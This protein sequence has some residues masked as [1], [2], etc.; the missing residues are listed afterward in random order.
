MK[1]AAYLLSTV[2]PFS[3]AVQSWAQMHEMKNLP[4]GAPQEVIA[5]SGVKGGLVVHLVRGDAASTADFLLN[6]SFLVHGLYRSEA[7]VAQ[8]R[9]HI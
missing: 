1:R 4:A 5:A 9:A 3:L 2:I 6:D 7:A 8:A